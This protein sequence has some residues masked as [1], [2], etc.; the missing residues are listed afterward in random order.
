MVKISQTDNN[1]INLIELIIKL[2]KSRWK[3]AVAVVIS[4]IAMTSYQ[5][6]KKNN[7]SAVTEIKP[8][9]T[10]VINKYIIF[11][12]TIELD[13]NNFNFKKITKSNIY[14]LYLE[15][16]NDKSVFVDAIRKF[17]LLDTS[18]YN[19]DQEYN[20][21]V[22]KLASTIKILNPSIEKEGNLEVPHHNIVF[23]HNNKKK[24]KDILAYVD[25]LTNQLVKKKLLEEYNNTL[26]FFKNN[27]KHKIERLETLMANTKIDFEKEIKKFEMSREF[28]IEDISTKI[29]N[30]L[31]DYDLNTRDRLIFLREQASIARE[32]EISK[33]EVEK[34]TIQTETS[35]TQQ[36]FVTNIK[37]NTPFYLRGYIAIEKEIEIIQERKIKDP[38][39][40]GLLNLRAEKRSL[41]Q[42]RTL[43]R[44]KKNKI[45]LD[46]L[47][48]LEKKKREI[49]QDKTI[50]KI[51]LAF[52]STPLNNN[53]G[54][55]SASIDFLTTKFEYK[56]NK[57]MLLLAMLIGLIA[58]I[59]YVLIS[60]AIISRRVSRKKTN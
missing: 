50:E 52:Q 13:K 8:I 1:E 44:V 56:N 28:K 12:N 17:N 59:F 29:N 38:F 31:L 37:T 39:V 58:G 47:I 15:I 35:D 41:E 23:K 2:W 40:K 10:S 20:E 18:Q 24:W 27:Q 4:F 51:Q 36:S 32:L 54:F 21:A 53:D 3:I 6:T 45:F 14:N 9:S 55:S 49:E 46:S 19:N 5:S 43:Q 30:A 26:L 42:D 11:N 16:L 22:I 7:F 60:N 48:E 25:V 33:K 57:Q 34:S